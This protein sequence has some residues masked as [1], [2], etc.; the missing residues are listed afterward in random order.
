MSSMVEAM[1][2]GLFL[3]RPVAWC[4]L[5]GD[6]I[7]K[8]FD[9]GFALATSVVAVQL[10]AEAERLKKETNALK[11]RPINCPLGGCE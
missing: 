11:A 8:H 1:G 6:E 5:R 10:Q 9:G 4:F 2:L 7:L 3:Y